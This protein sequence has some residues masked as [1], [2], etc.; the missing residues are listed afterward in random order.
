MVLVGCLGGNDE[1]RNRDNIDDYKI[2]FLSLNDGGIPKKAPLVFES[3]ARTFNIR[4]GD[5]AYSESPFMGTHEIIGNSMRF[6]IRKWASSPEIDQ[7]MRSDI[8]IETYVNDGNLVEMK[9]LRLNFK[10]KYEK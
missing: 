5:R 6:T 8:W 10:G 1:N 4:A 3:L 2:G 9:T 7:L